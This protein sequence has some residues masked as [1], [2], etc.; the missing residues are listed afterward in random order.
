MNTLFYALFEQIYIEKLSQIH[1]T[2]L[3]KA[4]EVMIWKS[5]QNADLTLSR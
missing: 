1:Y 3:Y 4:K 5:K 2:V